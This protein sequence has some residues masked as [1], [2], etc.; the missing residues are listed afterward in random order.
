MRVDII[1]IFLCR[2][3]LFLFLFLLW[4]LLETDR[5]S[6]QSGL[7]FPIRALWGAVLLG[8][9]L[10]LEGVKGIF[11][12]SHILHRVFSPAALTGRGGGGGGGGEKERT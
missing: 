11:T 1:Y 6:V 10:Q 5:L 12:T 2:V 8:E 4:V 7:Y 9:G 3:S